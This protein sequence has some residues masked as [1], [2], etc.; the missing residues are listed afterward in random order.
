[1][2]A[3]SM[4]EDCA[5]FSH[6][7]FVAGWDKRYAWVHEKDATPQRS[8]RGIKGR[9]RNHFLSLRSI[10]ILSKKRGMNVVSPR[11]RRT[12]AEEVVFDLLSDF[13]LAH[14][15]HAVRRTGV[16]NP[17]LLGGLDEKAIRSICKTSVEELALL[18]LVNFCRQAIVMNAQHSAAAMC[19]T[20]R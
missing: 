12:C 15:F 13:G 10:S 6:A 7:V 3:A 4:N 19:G 18:A 8:D 11:K 5:V 2:R 1:M 20:P 9:R 14:I 16:R 17:Q